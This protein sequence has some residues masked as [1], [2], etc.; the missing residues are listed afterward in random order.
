MSRIPLNKISKF[1]IGQ[2][3]QIVND[4][5]IETFEK[6]VEGTPVDKGQLR[7][8]WNPSLG[9]K[10]VRRRPRRDRSGQ[11]V[12]AE[13]T[14]TISKASY[15]KPKYLSNREFYARAV[16]AKRGFARRARAYFP[17]ALK[18]ATRRKFRL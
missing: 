4:A 11:K 16:E 14:K 12:R 5:T 8:G 13:I 7:G 17:T 10:R 1:L 6:A 3:E 18:K 9:R 15:K 2:V